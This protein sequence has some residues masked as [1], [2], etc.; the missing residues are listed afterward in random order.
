[1]SWLPVTWQT[2]L[3]TI[4]KEFSSL[5]VIG[6]PLRV[7]K[8]FDITFE[9]YLEYF[10][11]YQ[12]IITLLIRVKNIKIGKALLNIPFFKETPFHTYHVSRPQYIPTKFVSKI[13]SVSLK[14]GKWR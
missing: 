13:L 4:L 10:A 6:G 7:L 3:V 9:V 5:K 12:E 1:M 2:C 11:S 8:L 14:V